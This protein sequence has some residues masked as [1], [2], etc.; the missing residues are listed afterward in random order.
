MR[1]TKLARRR[2][3]AICAAT[4][5]LP[6]QAQAVAILTG[7]P[8]LALPQSPGSMSALES[9]RGHHQSSSDFRSITSISAA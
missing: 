6:A 2:D 8:P 5:R 3:N 4:E 7:P 9:R 1:P